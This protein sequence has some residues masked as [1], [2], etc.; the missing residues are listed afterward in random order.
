MEQNYEFVWF[1]GQQITDILLQ[2][3]SAGSDDSE[4]DYN[5]TNEE[6]T[7]GVSS[8]DSESCSDSSESETEL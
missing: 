7:G 5:E 1:E 2:H 6:V 8:E 4:E 3:A